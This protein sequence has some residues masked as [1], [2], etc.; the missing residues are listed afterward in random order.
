MIGVR[1]RRLLALAFAL[2]ASLAGAPAYAQVDAVA[3]SVFSQL[4]ALAA[5]AV[6]LGVIWMGVLVISRRMAVMTLLV[7]CIGIVIV[8]TGGMF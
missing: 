5:P 7:F 8:L 2:S 3:Q 1:L 6:L 4:T